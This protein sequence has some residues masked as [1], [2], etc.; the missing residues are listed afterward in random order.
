L[1][2]ELEFIVIENLRKKRPTAGIDLKM[3]CFFEE[4]KNKIKLNKIKLIF[5]NI[6]VKVKLIKFRFQ[7]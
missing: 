7:S 4:A 5:G 3:I 2:D 6:M 1:S